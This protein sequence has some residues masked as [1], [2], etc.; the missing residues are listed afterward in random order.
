MLNKGNNIDSG[1]TTIFSKKGKKSSLPNKHKLNPYKGLANYLFLYARVK[2][3]KES[4][5]AKYP[6]FLLFEFRNRLRE[7][8]HKK[9]FFL[10]VGPLRV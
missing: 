6:L 8:T 5:F 10:V 7:D 9:S 2:K 3:C 1:V 4:L